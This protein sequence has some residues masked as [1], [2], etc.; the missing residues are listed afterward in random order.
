MMLIANICV[1]TRLQG[2][3]PVMI[4]HG[5]ASLVY[6]KNPTNGKPNMDNKGVLNE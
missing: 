6:D 4:T 2:V 3:I 5:F 1:I